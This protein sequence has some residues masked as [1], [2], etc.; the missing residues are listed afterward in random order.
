VARGADL[1]SE[2]VQWL[3]GKATHAGAS[4][5]P[6]SAER[7]QKLVLLLPFR[8]PDTDK[9]VRWCVHIDGSIQDRGVCASLDELDPA[10][11]SFPLTVLLDP[12]D[13][14]IIQASLPAMSRK[15]LVRAIPY[16]LEDRL[17]GDVEQQ[18]FALMQS[19][20]ESTSVC[21][22]THERMQAILAA[23]NAAGLHPQSV[24]PAIQATPLPEN[25]WTIVFNGQCGWIRTGEFS[26]TPCNTE[27]AQPPYALKKMLL[28]VK[29]K[30]ASPGALLVIDAPEELDAKE[31]SSDLDLELMQPDG[32]FWENLDYRHADFNLL[33]GPYKQKSPT[34]SSINRL[35]LAIALLLVLVIGNVSVFGWDWLSLYRQS[36]AI[37]SEMVT[38]FKQSFPD[39]ASAVIDPVLQMQRNLDRLRQDRGGASTTDFLALLS[40]VSRVLSANQLQ[41]TGIKNIRYANRSIVVDVQLADYQ[42]LDR[43]KQAFIDEQLSV[44]V[45]Q[46]E[47]GAA[48]VRAKLK[49]EANQG[50][51][52]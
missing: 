52:S 10:L 41:N 19:T 15:N 38:I 12:F 1:I 23:L 3:P 33:Q 22:I 25:T 18:F 46:A 45:L 24:L 47:S 14:A 51:R 13:T 43:L 31:W 7:V 4:I 36:R 5:V 49:L 11:K 35:R 37:N 39:Q 6:A 42:N 34:Q 30:G 16:A 48:G 50:Q 9:G 21:V 2:M 40:P 27:D 32:E 26:G 8:W 17:L 20:R 29:E 44:E 28:D